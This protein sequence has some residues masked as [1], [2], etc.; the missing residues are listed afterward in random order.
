M[1]VISITVQTSFIQ[2][3][4][5]VMMTDPVVYWTVWKTTEECW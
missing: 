5:T 2:T 4:M 3:M 1:L